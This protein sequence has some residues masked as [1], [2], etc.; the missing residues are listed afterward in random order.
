MGSF[1]NYLG[2]T[3]GTSTNEEGRS[4]AIYDNSWVT[5]SN[6]PQR[7]ALLDSNDGDG[8]GNRNEFVV[9]EDPVDP[10][11][12]PDPNAKLPRNELLG[13]V[14]GLL[15]DD[16]AYNKVRDELTGGSALNWETF[17]F[18]ELRE[19]KDALNT[20]AIRDL[21]TAWRTHGDD[22]KRDSENFKKSVRNAITGKWEG[23]SADAAEAATQQVTKTSIYDFTPSSDALVGPVDRTEGS[24]RPYQDRVPPHPGRATGQ[25]MASSIGKASR[26]EIDE[27]NSRYHLDDGGRLRNNSDG[28]VT[29]ADALRE[30][31]E[32]NRSIRDYERAV[33]LFRVQLQ[34]DCRSGDAEFSRPSA[35]AEHAVSGR[36]APAPP[37]PAP[38]RSR[39]H[40]PWPRRSR[41]DGP[42]APRLSTLRNSASRRPPRLTQV[43][44]R[45]D[46]RLPAGHGRDQTPISDPQTSPGQQIPQIGS[47][48]SSPQWMRRSQGMKS[49]LDAATKAAQQAATG[50]GQKP[51][52]PSLQGG[53]ARTRRQAGR[54]KRLGRRCRCRWRSRRG[55]RQRP[56]ARASR[57]PGSPPNPRLRCATRGACGW[58]NAGAGAMGGMGAPGMGGAVPRPAARETMERNTR[59][60]KALKTRK[61]GSDIVGDT[62]AVVPV[63][64]DTPPPSR[65]DPA[66]SAAS[67]PNSGAAQHAWATRLGSQGG[68]RTVP[69][70][71]HDPSSAASDQLMDQ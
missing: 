36:R 58:I 68:G 67:P 32:I 54:S 70:A 60:N 16:T 1:G 10:D 17:T 62:D 22:L 31:E 42:S 34:P 53:C 35:P 39:P 26:R 14:P 18:V 5:N 27:F 50:T 4:G 24:L 65:R 44:R 33:Q 43:R 30:L 40:R 2:A 12:N 7:A 28:Y 55:R 20:E 19:E 66:A 56:T 25:R 49:G 29:A 51:A 63:L 46:P 52:I 64:G 69:T 3:M 23:D 48:A 71:Q 61:N 11:D 6:Y 8:D 38:D 37:V 21:A 13:E 59:A 57:R 47:R 9:V 15:S 41:P 45:S